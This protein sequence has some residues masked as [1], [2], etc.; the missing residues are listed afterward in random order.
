MVWHAILKDTRNL[1][2]LRRSDPSNIFDLGS[3]SSHSVI[4][5]MLLA[6][7]SSELYDL[8]D[9]LYEQW[10]RAV[11]YYGAT[12]SNDNC[13][14]LWTAVYVS[15]STRG[16]PRSTGLKN[17]RLHTKC[18]IRNT[19]QDTFFIATV[20]MRRAPANKKFLATHSLERGVG[21]RSQRPIWKKQQLLTEQRSSC[22]RSEWLFQNKQKVFFNSSLSQSALGS[23]TVEIKV[24][25][26]RFSLD[27]TIARQTGLDRQCT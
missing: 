20:L 15:T 2:M 10:S 26:R 13:G 24:S 27:D 23:C 4:F 16:L 3:T 11:Q 21:G 5:Q 9:V 17:I 7:S 8:S 18:L 14:L 19:V 22:D 6:T 1:K 12:C 25:A